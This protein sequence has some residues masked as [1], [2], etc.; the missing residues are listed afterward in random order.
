MFVSG[1]YLLIKNYKEGKYVKK[2]GVL[3]YTGLCV[4]VLAVILLM[5]SVINSLPGRLPKIIP[6]MIALIVGMIGRKLLLEPKFL[7]K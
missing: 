2:Y 3:A 1:G 5:E 7:K 4:W 6:G